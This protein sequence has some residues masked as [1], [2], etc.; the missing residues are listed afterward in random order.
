MPISESTWTFQDRAMLLQCSS[1][2][3]G[4][5][6]LDAKSSQSQARPDGQPCGCLGPGRCGGLLGQA[7]GWGPYQHSIAVHGRQLRQAL[8]HSVQRA[9]PVAARA[10]VAVW[11]DEG[12][13]AIIW[14]ILFWRPV[15]AGHMHCSTTMLNVTFIDSKLAP[16]SQSQRTS[17]RSMP[18]FSP[19][20]QAI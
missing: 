10:S 11:V 7:H 14:H 19:T 18:G 15:T 4:N 6:I 8:R 3:V 20:F 9:S 17:S 5:H 1:N 2:L 13:R 16:L 12:L